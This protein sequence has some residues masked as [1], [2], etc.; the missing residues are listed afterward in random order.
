MRYQVH[1]IYKEWYKLKYK[2]SHESDRQFKI[3]YVLEAEKTNV[4]NV[5]LIVE[6]RFNR[7]ETIFVES[8]ENVKIESKDAYD[9]FEKNIEQIQKEL[10]IDDRNR[11]GMKLDYLENLNKENY[12]KLNYIK[13]S[14]MSDKKL[15]WIIES[16]IITENGDIEG[17][18]YVYIDSIMGEVI[19][20]S[21][22]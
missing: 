21:K 8:N 10:K 12:S 3:N 19:G 9:I 2:S 18:L 6:K 1:L 11:I 7:N 14:E 17:K 5:L 16:D 4:P 15:C 20:A 13:E 22:E